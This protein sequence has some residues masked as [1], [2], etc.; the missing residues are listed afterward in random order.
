M[1]LDGFMVIVLVLGL[2]ALVAAAVHDVR[3]G[4]EGN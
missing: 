3:D 4:E 2:L 1:N